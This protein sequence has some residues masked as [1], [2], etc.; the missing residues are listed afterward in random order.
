MIGLEKQGN[1]NKLLRA[2]LMKH[3]AKFGIH[4]FWGVYI[5]LFCL[6]RWGPKHELVER[7][8]SSQIYIGGTSLY[9]QG[10]ICD[11]AVGYFLF[12]FK[13][14][15]HRLLLHLTNEVAPDRKYCVSP[16]PTH[17]SRCVI[18][19]HHQRALIDTARLMHTGAHSPAGSGSF[20]MAFISFSWIPCLHTEGL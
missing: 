1:K 7:S 8:N 10:C 19:N 15:I 3:Y 6:D 20:L 14:A 2:Q 16:T 4:I 5:V 12:C 18:I 11:S 17:P 9:Q 13:S